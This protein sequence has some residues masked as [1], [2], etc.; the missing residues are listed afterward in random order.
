MAECTVQAYLVEGCGV[1]SFNGIYVAVPFDPTENY[2]LSRFVKPGNISDE[3]HVL[4]IQST[5]PR[6]VVG[7]YKQVRLSGFRGSYTYGSYAYSRY[8]ICPDE[9][10]GPWELQN[11]LEP[12]P[13]SITAV[14]QQYECALNA[15][16]VQGCGSPEV[17]GI[18]TNLGPGEYPYTFYIKDEGK[19]QLIIQPGAGWP[20]NT[21]SNI[22]LLRNDGA[23]YSAEI[24]GVFGCPF[25]PENTSWITQ[26][27]KSRI[28]PPLH[29]SGPT[30]IIPWPGYNPCPSSPEVPVV[31]TPF[32]DEFDYYSD[33]DID[34][35]LDTLY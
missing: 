20:Y 26:Q 13:S 12:G 25:V 4:E 10:T 24:M 3:N 6:G 19:Y 9:A 23:K 33:I 16:L 35:V 7:P 14:S 2:V 30:C 8:L 21:G 34:I 18:Y 31:N 15:Y 17:D 28:Y 32:A 5:W 29:G 1:G 11:V 22:R 27:S